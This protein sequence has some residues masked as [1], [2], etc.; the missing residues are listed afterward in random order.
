L[1][2]KLQEKYPGIPALR[3]DSGNFRDV[4]NPIGD[5]RT[6]ALLQAMQ[7]LGYAVVN[8][9][10]RDVALGYEELLKRTEES[11][12]RFVSAN[13]VREDTREP[14]FPPHLVV[15]AVSP[16]GQTRRR[17]GVI[18]VMRFNPL[19]RKPGPDGSLLI[20]EDP[21]ERVRLEVESLRT[22]DVDTIVVLAAMH[23]VHAGKI[24]EQVPGIRCVLGS[25]GDYSTRR[26]ER[27][28]EAWIM[29]GGNRGQQV[30]EARLFLDSPGEDSARLHYLSD[31]YPYDPAM[32]DYVNA[33]YGSGV[34]AEATATEPAGEAEADGPAS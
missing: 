13:L 34:P 4:A 2:E 33:V 6:E 23:P 10:E 14:V 21:V 26:P 18:G 3:L 9:A 1:F 31:R 22:A 5:T 25:H 24:A 28:G 16:D 15:E 19:F 17:V 8:V 32:L 11:G 27:K 7:T 30:V 12:L 20:T 29:Y